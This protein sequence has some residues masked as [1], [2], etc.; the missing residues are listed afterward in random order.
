[1][2]IIAALLALTLASGAPVISEIYANP[3]DGV[4]FIELYNPGPAVNLTGWTIADAANNTFT[5]PNFTLQPQSY[6]LVGIDFGWTTVWNNGGDTAYLRNAT[7]VLMEEVTFGATTKGQSVSREL[8]WQEADPTPGYATEVQGSNLQ[9]T[10]SEVAPEISLELPPRVKTGT[11]VPVS[12]S[13]QDGNGDLAEWTLRSETVLATGTNA[14]SETASLL[15]PSP[16]SWVLELTASDAYG[17]EVTMIRTAQVAQSDLI[18][19][20]SGLQF[21]ALV[22]GEAVESSTFL[23][24]NAGWDT[25]T[26]VLDVSDFTGPQNISADQLEIHWGDW[27][28]YEGGLQTLPAMEPGDVVEVRFRLH[29]PTPL[30]AGEYGTSFTVTA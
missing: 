1:M 17:H 6:V 8:G 27:I 24:T 11:M 21:P 22:P 18:V 28:D 7:G 9:V 10:V 26:S 19:D 20:V 2:R 29:V 23:V 3:D 15:A 13:V 4:E 14:T 12:Y 25:V 16:G 30:A 5:F